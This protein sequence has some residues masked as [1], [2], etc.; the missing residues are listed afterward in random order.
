ML[1]FDFIH[2]DFV[3]FALPIFLRSNFISQITVYKH[4]KNIKNEY[5][6]DRIRIRAC[7]FGLFN[8]LIHLGINTI[9]KI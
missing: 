8:R 7:F 9:S 3:F 6:I 4:K 1:A 5:E 2:F